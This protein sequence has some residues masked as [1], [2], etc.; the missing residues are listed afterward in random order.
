MLKGIRVLDVSRLLPGPFASTILGDLGAEIIKIED[1]RGGDPLRQYQPFYKGESAFF[2]A[3]NRNKK[4]VTL[5][6][7]KEAGRELFLRL[8]ESADVVLEGFRPGVMDAL[9][10][11]Y[12]QVSKVN[13]GVIYCSLTGYGQDGPY[14]DRAGHDLNYITVSGL[15]GLT[16]SRGGPPVI[17][18]VQVGDLSGA[19]Y[20][21]ISILAALFQKERT[22]RG[23]YLDVAMTDVIFSQMV[24]NIALNEALGQAP[25]KGNGTLTGGLVCYSVYET[26]DGGYV[27]L[28]A[29]EP[30]FWRNFC[31]GTGRPD[32]IPLHMSLA[33]A[34]PGTL[35]EVRNIFLS[36]TRE[37][38]SEFARR[39]DCCLTPVEDVQEAILGEY[40]RGRDLLREVKINSGDL[41]RQV[42]LPLKSNALEEHCRRPPSLG[43]HTEEVLSGLGLTESEIGLLRKDGVI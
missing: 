11:G 39:V 17:P 43:E 27:A 38:W 42:R 15:L 30:K 25:E 7:K 28:G 3:V 22:G 36:R 8:A 13:P 34:D 14:R 21:V 37:Q 5:N 12:S 32:L 23:A 9:G 20:S 16:G 31:E 26:S 1:P 24:M 18:A 19:Q 40:A 4:S 2:L 33:A 35:A 10:V 6:L 41:I 29:L